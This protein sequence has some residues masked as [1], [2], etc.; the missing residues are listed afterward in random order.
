MRLPCVSHIGLTHG[1]RHD[2]QA[3]VMSD[4]EATKRLADVRHSKDA[5]LPLMFFGTLE[6][7]WLQPKDTLSWAA[8]CATGHSGRTKPALLADGIEQVRMREA[9][10]CIS[11]PVPVD[12]P[13]L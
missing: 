12:V 6:I 9:P 1:R 3:Q 10:C 7:A 4:R 13:C 8:G 5:I 2:P 11:V